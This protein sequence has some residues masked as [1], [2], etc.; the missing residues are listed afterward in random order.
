M[1]S[2]IIWLASRLL[3]DNFMGFGKILCTYSYSLSIYIIAG[4]ICIV[5]H[6]FL[7][8]FVI[9]LA[10][11]HSICFLLMNFKKLIDEMPP[12]FRLAVIFFV[13]FWQV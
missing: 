12:Q 3:A 6:N 2:V 11:A 13:I 8:E 7:R 10:C 1:F 4:L 9:W 5:P